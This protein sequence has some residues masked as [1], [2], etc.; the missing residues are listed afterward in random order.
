MYRGQVG[1]GITDA[2]VRWSE[3]AASGWADVVSGGA[4][5]DEQLS[6]TTSRSSLLTMTG[7][8]IDKTPE[9]VPYQLGADYPL[10]FEN[11]IPRYFGLRSHL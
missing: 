10:L 11:L 4:A 8:I 3:V 6:A 9:T 7:L 1:E 5:L 2:I